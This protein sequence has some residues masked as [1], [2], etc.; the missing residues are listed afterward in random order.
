MPGW[1]LTAGNRVRRRSA[2]AALIHA[3]NSWLGLGTAT[4]IGL[5]QP[6]DGVPGMRIRRL[7]ACF[8]ALR[9]LLV[10]TLPDYSSPPRCNVCGTRLHDSS[11]AH[12]PDCNADLK[13]V[14]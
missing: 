14:R 1:G 2:G 5:A 9:S 13:A 7:S 6:A 10:R 11:P 8:A 4:M 12:C 3:G